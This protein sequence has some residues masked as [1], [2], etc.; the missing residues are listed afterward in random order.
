MKNLII[1]LTMLITIVSTSARDV[2][3]NAVI[4]KGMA[5]WYSESDPGVL[6]TTANM[7]QFDETA[8]ACAIWG[9]PFNTI[10]KVTNLDNG[11]F[12]HVRVND[13]GPAKRLVR[14]G[15][16][17]DLTKTAF[18]MLDDLCKGLITVSIEII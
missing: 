3:S 15:R 17:I 2:A 13:R 5:S 18:S 4:F 14:G 16:V 6:E 9:L 8:L 10:L 1:I 7:E 12:I 11:N